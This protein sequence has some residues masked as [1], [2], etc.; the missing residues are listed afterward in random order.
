MMMSPNKFQNINNGQRDRYDVFAEW[1]AKWNKEWSSQLGLRHSTLKMDADD[2]QGYNSNPSAS[3]MTR[4]Y[5]AATNFNNQNHSK[6]DHN[7][8]ATRI[9]CS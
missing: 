5:S 6:T 3:A 8:D 4:Y 7:L 9:Q 1:D 2:I